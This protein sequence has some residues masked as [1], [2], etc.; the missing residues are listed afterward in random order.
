M[1]IYK[2]S[3]ERLLQLLEKEAVL[4]A[5]DSGGVDN[6]ENYGTAIN[7][8]LYD[9]LDENT[10]ITYWWDKDDIRFEEL[11]F[12]DIARENLVCFTELS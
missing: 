1:K 6:W 3:E 10:D 9:W 8:Y 12:S 4:S 7:D 11:Q 5:L 2:I